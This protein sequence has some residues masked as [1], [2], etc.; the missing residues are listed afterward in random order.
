MEVT[1]DGVRKRV[2]G[3]GSDRGVGACE[4]AGVLVTDTGRGVCEA[5]RTWTLY[6]G[7]SGNS[8]CCSTGAEAVSLLGGISENLRDER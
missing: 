5:C 8:G 4:G 3:I 1:S 6:A 7:S 2:A